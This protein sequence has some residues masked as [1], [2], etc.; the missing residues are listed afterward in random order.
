M[1]DPTI[2]ET[3]AHVHQAFSVSDDQGHTYESAINLSMSAY[4]GLS[5]Q[6]RADLELGEFN[7][8]LSQINTP[9]PFDIAAAQAQIADLQA[10]VA[11]YNNQLDPLNSNLDDLLQTDPVDQAAVDA[12][13]QQIAQIMQTVQPLQDQIAALQS[14][15]DQAGG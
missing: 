13:E 12:T 4:L 8:W 11:S 14:Q 2:T 6:D 15:I 3:E 5:A 7:G 10:Q 9:P 1:A